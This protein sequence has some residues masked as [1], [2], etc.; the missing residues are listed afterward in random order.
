MK[1]L[2]RTYITACLLLL[3]SINGFAQEGKWVSINDSIYVSEDIS[4]KQ[5]RQTLHQRARNLAL[6]KVVGIQIRSTTLSTQAEEEDQYFE[7]FKMITANDVRGKIIDERKPVYSRSVSGQDLLLHIEYEGKVAEE[8]ED[9]DPAFRLE[10]SADRSVY[11]LGEAVQLE[12]TPT[13]DAYITIFSI[14]KGNRVSMIFPNMYMN[15][16]FVAAHQ[17]R[18]IPNQQEAKVLEFKTTETEAIK[19]PYSEML[20]IIATK[21]NI[22]FGKLSSR[23]EYQDAWLKFNRM[24]MEVPLDRRVETFVQYSVVKR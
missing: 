3:G 13:K 6:E 23:V 14:L 21:E 15:D 5:A 24:L 22:E 20:M 1:L 8:D 9:P 17:T 7:S 19:A 16:N 4:M 12:V 10:A 2:Q 18:I 11:Q